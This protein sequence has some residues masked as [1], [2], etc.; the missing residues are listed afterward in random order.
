MNK[1]KAIKKV[2]ALFFVIVF[3]S[4]TAF[5]AITSGTSVGVTFGSTETQ[6]TETG[7]TS[8][9]SQK[10]DGQYETDT[11]TGNEN[12]DISDSDDDTSI[13]DGYQSGDNS[14][15]PNEDANDLKTQS[16]AS[17]ERKDDFLSGKYNLKADDRKN[18]GN[19]GTEDDRD[20]DVKSEEKL[21][22][23]KEIKDIPTQTEV[24]SVIKKVLEKDVSSKII[25]EHSITVDSSTRSKIQ[26]ALDKRKAKASTAFE[27]ADEQ[28]SYDDIASM[29]ASSSNNRIKESGVDIQ[30]ESETEKEV[31]SDDNNVNVK[32]DK[33]SAVINSAKISKRADVYSV[34]DQATNNDEKFSKITL[35]TKADRDYDTLEIVESIPKTVSDSLYGVKFDPVPEIVDAPNRI[36]RWSYNDV[37]SGDTVYANYIVKKQVDNIS[38]TTL[39]AGQQESFF[40]KI[41]NI[42]S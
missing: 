21:D 1:T 25:R 16:S 18:D 42:F 28:L 5:A 31:I 40:D 3:L 39:V 2:L 14:D 20:K 36:V 26:E 37:K 32:L 9:E 12:E 24:R 4:S 41:L 6:N 10:E 7:T 17:E 29:S 27:L 30:K 33:G 35:S 15:E 8:T 22:R 13:N 38:T 11:D 23:I 34:K 19:D